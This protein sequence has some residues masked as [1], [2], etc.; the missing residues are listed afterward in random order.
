MPVCRNDGVEYRRCGNL[1]FEGIFEVVADVETGYVDVR[2]RSVVEF[3]PIVLLEGL[4]DEDAVGSTDFVDL[5]RHCQ[6]SHKLFVGEFFVSG[7]KGH[8]IA[9]E[10]SQV[11]F[12]IFGNYATLRFLTSH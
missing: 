9:A 12:C 4:V 11:E 8:G 2:V 7:Y 6:V 10:R 1:I 3:Q 5:D